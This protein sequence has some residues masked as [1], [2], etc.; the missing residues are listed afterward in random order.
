MKVGGEEIQQYTGTYWLVREDDN[1]E[2]AKLE[3][4]IHQ[5]PSRWDIEAMRQLPQPKPPESNRQ[6]KNPATGEFE[7]EK[8]TDSPEY[9]EALAEWQ[10]RITAKR[11]YDG[12]AKESVQFEADTELLKSS[13]SQFYDAIADELDT[14][15]GAGEVMHWSTAIVGIGQVG[16]YDVAQSQARVFP[17]ATS[18]KALPIS[19]EGDEE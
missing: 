6:V 9:R 5:L 12:T 4:S 18:S 11:I 15:T 3:I 14:A 8:L 19:D 10:R 2:L 1:G 7:A 16:G 13:P 17:V